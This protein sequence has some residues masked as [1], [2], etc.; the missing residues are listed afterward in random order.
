MAP[1][2]YELAA[3]IYGLTETDLEAGIVLVVAREDDAIIALHT[4]FLAIGAVISF[5][6][7]V[8]LSGLVS[9]LYEALCTFER[10]S[11]RTISEK[12]ISLW[13]HSVEP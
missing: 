12:V 8:A 1:S 11:V 7:T 4:E 3:T 13:R 5:I 2:F 10:P 9:Q 6:V